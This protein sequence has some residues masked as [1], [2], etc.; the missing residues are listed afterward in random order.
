MTVNRRNVTAAW[1]SPSRR[2]GF[3]KW[4]VCLAPQASEGVRRWIPVVSEFG[5]R[6][7]LDGH[8]KYSTRCDMVGN[9]GDSTKETKQ[10][11]E[12]WFLWWRPGR[13]NGGRWKILSIFAWHFDLCSSSTSDSRSLVYLLNKWTEKNSSKCCYKLNYLDFRYL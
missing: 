6:E 13:R 8:G 9:R 12:S 10:K 7:A 1:V 2:R 3:K 5:Q 11:V 4:G